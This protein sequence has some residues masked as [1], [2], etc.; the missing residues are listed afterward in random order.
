MGL[1]SGMPNWIDSCN[2][3]IVIYT[4]VKKWKEHDHL[5]SQRKSIEQI[6]FFSWLKNTKQQLQN[7]QQF[8][9]SKK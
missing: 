1:N 8:R 3:M 9:S 5:R 6:L 4:I 7:Y 2:L